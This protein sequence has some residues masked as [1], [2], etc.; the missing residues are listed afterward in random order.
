MVN[1]I[2]S[3]LHGGQLSHELHQKN[4]IRNSEKKRIWV[5]KELCSEAKVHKQERKI[6]Q[7][8]YVMRICVL[9]IRNPENKLIHAVKRLNSTLQGV[10][11]AT[12]L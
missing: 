11:R 3:S 9:K 12:L 2:G 8:L 7:F 6:K 1:F 10:A 4:L 5:R